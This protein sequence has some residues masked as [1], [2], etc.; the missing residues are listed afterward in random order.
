MPVP[1]TCNKSHAIQ[2]LE[3]LSL[4]MFPSYYEVAVTL[5]V[6]LPFTFFMNMQGLDL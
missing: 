2:S 1:N 6:S 4:I 5:K 3:A